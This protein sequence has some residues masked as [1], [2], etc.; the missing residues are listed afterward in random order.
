MRRFSTIVIVFTLFVLACQS[1]ALPL[2]RQA[3]DVA[4]PVAGQSS[5]GQIIPRTALEASPTPQPSKTNL[6]TQTHTPSPTTTKPAPTATPAPPGG[7]QVRLHPDGGL[8]VGDQVSVEVIAPPNAVLKGKK[9][10]VRAGAPQ[11]ENG[12][13]AQVDAALRRSTRNLGGG[14]AVASPGALI[15]RAEFG[16]F[17][18]G[19]RNQATLFWAWD[20]AG[21]EPGAHSL[22][23]SI[24]PGGPSWTE[25]VT[26]LPAGEVPYPEPQ[27]RWASTETDCCL[28][29]YITGTAAER[30]LDDLETMIEAQAES[31]EKRFGARFEKVIPIVLLPRVMGHGGF[32]DEEISVSYLDR[33]YAGSSPELVLHHELVHI[34]DGR[35]GGELRPTLFVEGLAVYLS[36]GHFK[37]EALMPRMAALLESGRYVPLATLADNFYPAQHETGYLEAAALIEFMVNEWGWQAFTA[38][39]RDIHPH[40][41]KLQSK[42]IEVALQEHFQV[43]FAVMEQQFIKALRRLPLTEDIRNDARLTLG[44]YDEVRRYQQLLDPSAYFL[45]AWLPGNAELRERGI[46]A[47]YVRRPETLENI[48]LEALLVSTD[49]RLRAFDYTSARRALKAVTAVLDRVEARLPNP[50]STNPMAADYFGIVQAL[51][52][53]GYWPQRIEVEGEP[54]RAWV[55]RD[56]GA[57]EL[58]RLIKGTDGWRVGE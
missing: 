51:Q 49:E 4:T 22:S 45:T 50:F 7:F 53:K 35:Q 41:D 58:V 14:G 18:I 47:D 31:V 28:V 20:T 44:F 30:D 54:P 1:L 24:Q 16:P 46:V 6:P 36:G 19:E 25:T 48:A 33:N 27:A 26:L 34:L 3:P 57:P 11:L 38:F 56:G 17:G 2:A 43:S 23:F 12:I 39:Y 37:P 9:V 5:P 13:A 42:A 40:P 10:E 52:A 55:T 8:Y 21:L 29:Y 32:A 15:G